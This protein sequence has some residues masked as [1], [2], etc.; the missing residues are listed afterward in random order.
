MREIIRKQDNQ[1]NDL[2]LTIE[3]NEIYLTGEMIIY[4]ALFCCSVCAVKPRSE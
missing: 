3:R 4:T 1:V 2:P